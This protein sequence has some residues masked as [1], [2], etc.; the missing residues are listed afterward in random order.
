M[1]SSKPKPESYKS[2][3]KNSLNFFKGGNSQLM[4]ARIQPSH[5]N[6]TGG[7]ASIFDRTLVTLDSFPADEDCNAVTV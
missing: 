5:R 2:L 4:L 6:L 7:L 3:S 1:D